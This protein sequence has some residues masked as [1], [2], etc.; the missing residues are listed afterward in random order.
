MEGDENRSVYAILDEAA[1]SWWYHRHLR[2]RGRAEEARQRERESIRSNVNYLRQSVY[3][4]IGR[5]GWT[6][7]AGN[8]RLS[9]HY[10]DLNA[11]PR[12]AARVG[13]PV[14]DSRSIP[15]D[16]LIQALH[17]PLVATEGQ[18]DSPPWN[19]LSKAPLAYV[20]AEYKKLGA[21]VWNVPGVS[22]AQQLVDV[23]RARVACPA[24][25]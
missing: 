19:W 15:E 22:E 25:I 20:A 3:V 5:H 10:P 16:L 7:H 23:A 13:L 17:I 21:T 2:Q 14:L 6:A 9:G 24:S 8:S 4:S 1:R 18:A 12:L 11:V